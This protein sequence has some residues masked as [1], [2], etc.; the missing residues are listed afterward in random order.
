MQLPQK[1]NK[2]LA[3]RGITPSIIT[4]NIGWNGSQ[5]VIPIY[6][7]AG[8]F[9]FN[10]YRRDPFGPTST[11]KYKYDPGTKSQLYNAHKIPSADT[12]II[13]EGEM[14]ALRLESEGYT[15]VSSTGG[16]GTF[17]NDWLSL[18][19]D[20]QVFIC[21]DNDDAGLKGAVR[22]LE[23]ISAKLILVPRI[24]QVKDITEYLQYPQHRPF[25]SLMEEAQT[26]SIL[27][28]PLP[29]YRHVKDKQALI[30]KYKQYLEEL[31]K[32]EV[33]ADMNQK[34]SW[35]FDYIRQPLLANIENLERQIRRKK[36]MNTKVSWKGDTITGVDILRAKEIPIETF[37]T[38]SLRR[39][40]G[41]M[42]GLCPFHN[43]TSSSFV[44]FKNNK[45][46]CFGACSSGGTVVDFY[47]RSAGCDFITAIKKLLNK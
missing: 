2:W 29:E 17:Q 10:K 37:Y 44:I 9:L 43:E 38:G 5:I 19:A 45:W 46:W 40:G 31:K 6:D 27:L 8:N 18:F 11:P 23:K 25:T 35:H 36:F 33:Q 1:I 15:A 47:M 7:P 21:Y 39:M 12:I 16:S 28:G 3:N 20:K 41:R 14:D 30:K 4:N 24:A 32:E 42:Y 22:L 13:T 34:A 26:Y